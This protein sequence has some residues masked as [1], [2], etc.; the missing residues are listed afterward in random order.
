MG[1]AHNKLRESRR[2]GRVQ[3]AVRRRLQMRPLE[4]ETLLVARE[5]V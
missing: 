2:R 5:Q 1:I 3:D 4:V